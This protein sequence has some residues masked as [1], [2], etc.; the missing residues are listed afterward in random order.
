[1]KHALAIAFV[2]GLSQAVALSQSPVPRT[3]PNVSKNQAPV[4]NWENRLLAKDAKVRATAEAALVQ[5]GARSLPLL[6]RFLTP[7]HED[8]HVVTFEIIR[9]IGPPAIPLL[10]D[11]LRHEWDSV[12]REAVD[13]L[14]DL[15]PHTALIQPALRRALKDDDS[16]V[17]GDAARALGALG[18]RATPSVS[19]LINTLSHE[20]SY[21]RIYAAEALASIGPSAAAATNALAQALDDPVPGVR[22]AACE[23]LASIGPPAHAAVPRLIEALHDEFLYVRIFAAGALGSIGPKAQSAREALTA[24]ANDPA[25]RD[26]VQWALARIGESDRPA[27]A[28]R[29]EAGAG[30]EARVPRHARDAQSL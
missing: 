19:A 4:S 2:A 30:R 18:T 6:R 23:A 10:V 7:E 29:A 22:W 14:I 27:A 25:L 3:Q 15:A 13:A 11:L 21:V 9:R 12:R 20:N 28:L 16:I 26:E 17:A 8:L 5:G 1:M 24:A